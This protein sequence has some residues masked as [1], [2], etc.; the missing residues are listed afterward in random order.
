MLLPAEFQEKIDLGVKGLFA[1]V[2]FLIMATY[3]FPPTEN[4]PLAGKFNI[5]FILNQNKC[6]FSLNAGIFY[7]FCVTMIVL[8]II[9]SAFVL[10]I[11]HHHDGTPPSDNLK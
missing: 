2:V 9:S 3:S 6:A 10:Q 7:L 11:F 4:I 5:R 8:N 1:I